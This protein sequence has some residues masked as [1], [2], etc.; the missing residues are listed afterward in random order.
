MGAWRAYDLRVFAIGEDGSLTL[1]VRERFGRIGLLAAFEHG[2]ERLIAL[3][4]DDLYATPTCS[5]I[6]RTTVSP[7]ACTCCAG[8][9][10]RSS[11][12][13]TRRCRGTTP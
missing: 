12:P 2:A 7:P 1:R 4:K 10:G 13:G 5:A 8:P 3:L 6:H 9:A 11:R